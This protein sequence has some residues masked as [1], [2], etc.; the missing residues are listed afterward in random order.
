MFFNFFFSSTFSFIC[1]TVLLPKHF[2][3]DHCAVF[4]YFP[5]FVCH[6]QAG[7]LK[8]A[9]KN[10]CEFLQVESALEQRALCYTLC[11]T[12]IRNFLT[13][14]QNFSMQMPIALLH[15]LNIH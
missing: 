2:G 11:G 15:V 14:I 3:I 12:M 6:L 4:L 8:M 9:W 13:G 7:F 1:Q 5:D 10:F